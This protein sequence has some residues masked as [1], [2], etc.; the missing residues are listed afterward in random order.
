M[1]FFTGI[2]CLVASLVCLSW[3]A[4]SQDGS[5]SRFEIPASLRS[6]R[7]Q[8][9][10]TAIDY[11]STDELARLLY[12]NIFTTAGSEPTS[13]TDASRIAKAC[14]F[15]LLTGMD[16]TLAPLST[17]A[18]AAFSTRLH[19]LLT[20]MSVD[21]EPTVDEFQWR[22][23]ELMQYSTAYDF[24]RTSTGKD[25]AIEARL[26][27]FA[28]AALARLDQQFVVRNNLSIKL[29]A[30]LGYAG[31]MLRDPAGE[32][33]S[34]AN[35]WFTTAYRFIEETMW[36]YQSDSTGVYGYSEGPYYFRYAMMSAIPFFLA[37]D[38]AADDNGLTIGSELYPSPLRQERW[39][40]LFE[41]IAAIRMPDGS[42]PL[43][44]DTYANTFFPE[45]HI[46]PAVRAGSAL[47]GWREYDRQANPLSEVVIASELTRTFDFRIEYLLN[48]HF[49]KTQLSTGL[50]SSIMPDAGYAV[51]RN[52]WGPRDTYFG[53][54]GKH[55]VPRTHRS[56]VGSGHKH[57][58]E[59]AFIL[60]S[61]GESLAMEPGYHSSERRDSLVFARNHNV[62]LVDGR[63]ADSVSYGTF[64]FG[65]EAFIADTLSSDMGGMVSITT[66]YQDAR[67]ER[68]AYVLDWRFIVLR[69]QVS[70]SFA[71]EFTQQI[72]GNGNA[73]AGTFELKP[74]TRVARWT[75]RATALS[76]R[77]ETIGMTPNLVSASSPHAPGY[78][79]FSSHEVLRASVLSDNAVFHSVLLPHAA[80]EAVRFSTL[81]ADLH[82][83]VLTATSEGWELMSVAATSPRMTRVVHPTLG[84]VY[85]NG[86]AWQ[87]IL[88]PAGRPVQW[89]LDEG[90]M[91][92][93]SGGR[94]MLS[95]PMPFSALTRLSNDKMELSLRSVS[96]GEVRV[97][98]PYLPRT[99]HGTGVTN[100]NVTGPLLRLF[101]DKP[102]AD[103]V[104]DFS[105]TP[106]AISG[107]EALPASLS[108]DRPWPNPVVR[109]GSGEVYIS[110]SLP[111]NSEAYLLLRDLF[112]R[113]VRRIVERSNDPGAQTVRLDIHGLPAGVYL[114]RLESNG[115]AL[116]RGLLIF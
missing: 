70:S 59:G 13:P 65:A 41:W 24:Y 78:K 97:R 111:A 69:D 20:T 39:Q 7:P 44:E 18:R 12:H 74:D 106:T 49:A 19:M 15:V 23:V 115:G 80:S 2:S 17:A 116:Q 103:I 11:I 38:A 60:Y 8:Q 56:P 112:G 89:M 28:E 93:R 36:Y 55:G 42:L 101:L 114:L 45:L 6:G 98:I 61:G 77:V 37:L 100:W 53:L 57:A 51:F 108:L 90:S 87:C 16:T 94:I 99:V 73:A 25:A 26:A 43:F 14:G 67:I 4:S 88:D 64:L 32:P 107:A 81:P 110:Y 30:A 9:V 10:Y 66:A 54:I 34:R 102:D 72:H 48:I 105:G 82:A 95:S 109:G 27:S 63:G 86:R 92:E 35:I 79:T 68:R 85:G 91:I 33:A 71:R 1:S 50:P 46:L 52:G 58:N 29:A 96:A 3:P 84:P 40:G 83:S 75:S 62:I 76:A 21:V 113:E 22:A 47:A 5:A 31:L 104:I